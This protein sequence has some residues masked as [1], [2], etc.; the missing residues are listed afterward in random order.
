MSPA[1]RT[2][3]RYDNSTRRLQAAATGQRIVDA[4]AELLRCSPIRDWHT[5]TVRAVAERAGVNE[6]TVYRHF[7]ND[8]GLR[9]AIMSQLEADSGVELDQLDLDRLGD[10]AASVLQFAAGYPAPAEPQLDP[11]LHDA[12][13]RRREALERVVAERATGW[14]D[15]E[16]RRAAAAIDLL[17]S[18]SAYERLRNSWQLDGEEAIGAI[19]WAIELVADAARSAER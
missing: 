19:T 7:G 1:A 5:V 17:W 18:L 14:S 8:K 16:Q 11:T 10:V 13:R 9:D 12:D 3:R 15:A 4:G 6:R 2:T